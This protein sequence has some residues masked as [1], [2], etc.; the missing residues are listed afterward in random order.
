MR[1]IVMRSEVEGAPAGE[2]REVE[3]R[4]RKGKNTEAKD[5]EENILVL[6]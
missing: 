6:F 5:W 3:E 1:V 4:A 2:A